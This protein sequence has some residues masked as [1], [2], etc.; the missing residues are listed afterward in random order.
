MIVVDASVAV[1]WFLKEKYSDHAITLLTLQH[2][3]VG[4]TL[5]MYEVASAFSRALKRG[6]IDT[7]EAT[8]CRD[9]WLYAIKSSVL[10]LEHDNRDIVRASELAAKLAH[11]F[12]DCVYL[13]LAERLDATLVTADAVFIEKHQKGDRVIHVHDVHSLFLA[14]PVLN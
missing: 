10:R 7:D 11:P 13:A 9:R 5:A 14:D 3:L 1:K 2:K 12:A 6:D 8:N 4:P